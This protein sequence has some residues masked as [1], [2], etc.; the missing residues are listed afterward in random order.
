MTMG[1]RAWGPV[2]GGGEGSRGE[3]RARLRA[4]A[5]V[6][7][8]WEAHLLRRAHPVQGRVILRRRSDLEWGWPSV[9]GWG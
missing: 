1:R 6:G 4:Q 8:G 3:A 7:A 2:L 5:L 9:V